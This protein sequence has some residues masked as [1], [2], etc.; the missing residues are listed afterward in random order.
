MFNSIKQTL[1]ALLAAVLVI[2]FSYSDAAAE[3]RVV[4]LKIQGDRS[5]RIGKSLRRMLDNEHKVLDGS[6]YELEAEKLDAT[7]MIPR[8]IRKVASSIEADGVLTGRLRR[9]RGRYELKLLLLEGQ[10]GKA[11][12]VLT[13]RLRRRRLSRRMRRAIVKRLLGAIDELALVEKNPESAIKEDDGVGNSFR[14]SDGM[15]D[16]DL[17]AS[18]KSDDKDEPT[19]SSVE[20]SASPSSKKPSDALWVAAGMSVVNRKLSFTTSANLAEPPA[21]Y[22]GPMAPG[23]YVEAE[24]FPLAMDGKRK[25]ALAN[26]GFGFTLDKVVSIKTI[27]QDPNGGMSVSLPTVQTQWGAS[28]KYRH[29]LSAKAAVLLRVGY[30]RSRFTVDR[31]GLEM[32]QVLDLPNTNYTFYDPGVVVR[33]K[34]SPKLTLEVDGRGLLVTNAGEIQTPEQYGSAKVTGFDAGAVIR[35]KVKPRITLNIGA[36][37]TAIGYDFN[38][39]GEQTVSRDNDPNTKDVGG[40]LDTYLRA[41]VS[42]GYLF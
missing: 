16:D 30:N 19:T 22:S 32:G 3:K 34:T 4:M 37:Y 23:V 5:A 35:Y 20:K 24:A 31:S 9:R 40:A 18:D 42:L 12:K 15:K 38:G 39:D 17:G 41:Q 29:K 27:L 8:N 10:S 14:K 11:I 28:I 2:G 21:G 33:Y 6:K 7:R 1:I 36:R 13:V 25:D 26:V